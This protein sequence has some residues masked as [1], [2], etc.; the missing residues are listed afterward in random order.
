MKIPIQH[1]A[2]QKIIDLVRNCRK[3]SYEYMSQRYNGWNKSEKMDRAF[4]DVAEKDTKGR[5]MNPFERQVYIPMSRAILDTLL[6]YWMAVICGKRPIFKI[7]GRGG[8]DQMPAKK[9]EIIIDYQVERQRGML[10]IYSFLRDLGK[11]GLSS[12]KNIFCRNYQNVF[13]NEPQIIQFPFPHTVNERVQKKIMSYEGPQLS[14][15]DIYSFFP[16]TRKPM[17]K[18]QS[19][20]FV[21][22][23]YTRSRYE[24]LKQQNRGVYF[25]I[26]ELKTEE[27]HSVNNSDSTSDNDNRNQIQGIST[28]SM[29][30]V[31]DKN[32]SYKLKEFYIEI[33]PRDYGLDSIE[34][35]EESAGTPQIWVFA[36]VND[37]VVIRAE[38]MAYAHGKFPNNSA[39][40]DYDGQSLFNQSFYESVEGLQDL[41]NWL[42]NSR[43]SN[44]RSWL[45]NRAV[46]DPSVVNERDL[47][48]PNPAGLIRLKKELWQKGV[49]MDNVFKQLEV[50][51]VTRSH[52]KDAEM[53]G[54]VMQRRH[55]TPDSL[56]GVETKI[57]RT[58][59]EIG[60][61]HNSGA[62]HLQVQAQIIYAQAFVEMAEMMVQN[63]QQFLS[64][65][66]Y[67]R[68]VGDYNKKLIQPDPNYIGA[69]AIKAGPDDIQG[70][71]DFPIDDGTMPTR[72][73][74][75]AD[76]WRE[77]FQA[78]G[79]N[80]ILQQ[81]YDVD[82][83]FKQLCE[84]LNVKNIDD[85]IIQQAG[86]MNFNVIPDE[87]AAAMQQ[88]GDVIPIDMLGR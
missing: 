37:R 43:M 63:N 54:D 17:G 18:M 7:N 10:A 52:I 42:Y 73:Q 70:F 86:P 74:D 68:I 60:E 26:E 5:K 72:P 57:K 83:I 35:F 59:T 46:I 80:P 77:I 24:L 47:I 8:E 19:G 11:Y 45:M 16:D 4:I 65:E 6:T 3:L 23:E 81:R 82:W 50:R 25:N 64:E 76:I 15:T 12:I 29:R 85:A 36:T 20:Q 79:A 78:V 66:R 14:N 30:N 22:Y 44:V 9:M 67:F 34:G 28:T 69:N 75:F 2:H 21:G 32:P 48:K 40:F 33:I 55:H 84:A 13:A 41:M 87:Q 53:I 1:P 58:A 88:S 27:G 38:K 62:N 31:D 61:M 56:Q 39:E 49:S 71:F 51:D